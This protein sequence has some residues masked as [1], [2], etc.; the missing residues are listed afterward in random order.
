[1]TGQ[2]SIPQF[3]TCR[4]RCERETAESLAIDP[5]A[6]EIG[7]ERNLVYPGPRGKRGFPVCETDGC[8]REAIGPFSYHCTSHWREDG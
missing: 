5:S 6:L 3:E 2:L 8:R 1:M 7:A 4:E